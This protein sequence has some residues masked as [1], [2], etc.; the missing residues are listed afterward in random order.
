M[1]IYF[2]PPEKHKHVVN[3]I[4]WAIR[5][6]YKDLGFTKTDEQRQKIRDATLLV[7]EDYIAEHEDLTRHG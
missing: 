7:I 4:Q 1:S 2:I 6:M 5:N 3:N